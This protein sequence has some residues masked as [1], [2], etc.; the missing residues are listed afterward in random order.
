MNF[1]PLL[2]S[3]NCMLFIFFRNIG[4]TRGTALRT[5]PNTMTYVMNALFQENKATDMGGIFNRGYL[6]WL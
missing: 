1:A 4:P 2:F 5:E 6:T 3:Y